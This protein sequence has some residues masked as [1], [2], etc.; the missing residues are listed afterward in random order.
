MTSL[1][2]LFVI[3]F[4]EVLAAPPATPIEV[5]LGEFLLCAIKNEVR[6]M[7]PGPRPIGCEV[8]WKDGYTD[9]IG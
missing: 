4:D 7:P 2:T 1:S 3:S 6:S 5:F 9:V 8:V